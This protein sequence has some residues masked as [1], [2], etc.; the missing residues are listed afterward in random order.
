[1]KYRIVKRVVK[2]EEFFHVE[3]LFTRTLFGFEIG[4]YWG[5]VMYTGNYSYKPKPA[6]FPNQ[7]EAERILEKVKLEAELAKN[8][9]EEVITEIE[10]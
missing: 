7:W 10:I 9:S 8:N 2:S 5:A 6:V 1:M 4:T 3:Q